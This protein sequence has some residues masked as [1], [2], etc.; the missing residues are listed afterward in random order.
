MATSYV[1]THAR[2]EFGPCLSIQQEH[3]RPFY[4]CGAVHLLRGA[5]QT[6]YDVVRFDLIEY[7]R[8]DRSVGQGRLGEPGDE[9]QFADRR[10]C[11]DE[12]AD[13]QCVDSIFDDI[14]MRLLDGQIERN[15]KKK[16]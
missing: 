7:L 3:V 10:L 2:I 11:R 13:I 14:I 5:A 16:N 8:L 15:C 1:D 6:S 9:A 12:R 4:G